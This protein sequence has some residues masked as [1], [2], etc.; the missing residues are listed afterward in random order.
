[1]ALRLLLTYPGST[2]R[3]DR[4]HVSRGSHLAL[5]A[6]LALCLVVLNVEAQSPSPAARQP[7]GDLL[8]S[9]ADYEDKVYASWLGANHRQHR[10]PR[11]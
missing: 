6:S 4:M 8:P 7:G 11:P 10:R 2:D 5:A 1:M 9:A 3:R